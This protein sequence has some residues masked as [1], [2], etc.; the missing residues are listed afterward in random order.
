[1]PQSLAEAISRVASLGQSV[2]LD[3]LRRDWL[4]D[5]TLAGWVAEGVRGVTSNPT[6]FRAAFQGSSAYDAQ[7]TAA[8]DDGTLD[9]DALYDR[10]TLADIQAACDI[11]R[12]VWVATG[13]RDGWVSHEVD[14]ALA[15]DAEGTVAEAER[16]WRALDRTNAMIKIPA[17]SAGLTAVRRSLAA[18]IPINVTLVFSVAQ[19]EAVA[20]AYLTA[21]EDRLATGLPLA[22][23]ASVASLFISRVDAALTDRLRD[24]RSGAASNQGRGA[25][26]AAERAEALAEAATLANARQAYA[27]FRA[28]FGGPRFARLARRGA[29]PQ[30]LLFASTAV[31]R[32]DR[33]ALTF[34]A[35]LVGPDT[36]TTLPPATLAALADE[37]RWTAALTA[38][39]GSGDPLAALRDHGIDLEDVGQRL[40]LD[41]VAAFRSAH[42]AAVETLAGALRAR[43]ATRPGAQSIR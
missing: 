13:G 26:Q 2:W 5:G 7:I 40:T 32:A 21:L 30:R 9:A 1:M 11:L 23:V 37:P 38:P 19:Y 24:G 8:A 6:I 29:V 35:P 28:L 12:P 3:A 4:A 39:T 41:G 22:P 36:A 34:V 10:L 27:R 18:G 31:K 20:D 43:S 15:D 17:T 14:P 33:P 16:L 25:E 42:E